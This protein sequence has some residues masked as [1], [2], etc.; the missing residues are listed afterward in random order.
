MAE[1]I[2][3]TISSDDEAAPAPAPAPKR[4]VKQQTIGPGAPAA[5][6]DKKPKIAPADDDDDDVEFLDENPFAPPPLQQQAKK[7]R[8]SAQPRKG[9][10]TWPDG[11]L[12]LGQRFGL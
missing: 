12:P 11:Y 3:C 2:D 10:V 7:F 6:V 1:I 8:V 4:R 9:K 5:H